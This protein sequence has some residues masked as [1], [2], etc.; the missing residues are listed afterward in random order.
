MPMTWLNQLRQNF[1]LHSIFFRR[2]LRTA[3]ALFIGVIIYRY[4]NL[5][6]GFWVPLTALIVM[7][8]TTAATL[9]KGL[10]RFLGTM[11]GVVLGTLAVE[12]IQVSYGIDLLLIVFFF[13]TYYLKSF[14]LVNYGIYVV[15]LTVAVVFLLSAIVPQ[16]AQVLITARL[17]DTLIGAAL[18][19]FVTLFVFPNSLRQDVTDGMENLITTQYRYLTAIINL[20]L[21]NGNREQ[22]AKQAQEVRQQFECCLSANRRYFAD[23]R[24]ELWVR[25]RKAKTHENRLRLSEKM[26]QFLFSLHYLA[27]VHHQPAEITGSL[28]LALQSM[29]N[30]IQQNEKDKN[31]DPAALQPFITQIQDLLVDSDNPFLATLRIDL[32]YYY[33]CLVAIDHII[34]RAN[35]QTTSE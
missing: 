19:V 29:L 27:R 32:Q 22:Q 14:N 34:P 26:G 7:Q 4:F 17:Y 18:G 9:R 20:L 2:A 1:N 28:R 33:Q 24:Y 12:K 10:Q 35:R 16:H 23:W 13:I 5:T 3:I 8:A 6:Q 15:P 30:T 31:F 11:L 25:F 21:Q